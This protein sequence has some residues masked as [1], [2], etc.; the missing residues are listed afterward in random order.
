MPHDELD[1]LSLQHEDCRHDACKLRDVAELAARLYANELHPNVLAMRAA[2]LDAEAKAGEIGRQMR[3][4]PDY[5]EWAPATVAGILRGADVDSETQP[6][7]EDHRRIASDD[8]QPPTGEEIRR[9]A[10]RAARQRAL[11]GAWF[12]AELRGRRHE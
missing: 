2:V 7:S 6:D 12:L 8:D 4:D 5:D 3:A 11:L 9:S 1:R 10:I